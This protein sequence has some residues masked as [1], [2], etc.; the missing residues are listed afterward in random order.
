V[1]E[2]ELTIPRLSLWQLVWSD[3]EASRIEDPEPAWI[4]RLLYLPRLALNPSLQFA[5]LVRLAQ[6]GPHFLVYPLRMIQ[7]LLFSSE[8]W[9]FSGDDAIEIGPGI[10]FPHPVNVIIGAGTKIGA[11]VTGYNNTN[12]GAD[13]HRRRDDTVRNAARI[14]DRVV[15]YAYSAVQG[16][17]DVGQDAVVGIHVVLDDN[18]PAGA[19]RTM[20][21]LRS[22]GEWPGE[23]RSHYHWEKARTSPMLD[24]AQRWLA[25]RRNA[26]DPERKGR[27]HI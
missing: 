9:M 2:P 20:K 21:M 23:D 7:V 3:Y 19:L 10:A 1:A 27:R 4:S 22:A 14:G 11:G 17:Y 8:V 25:R 5:L 13:R 24:M 6:K 18:V 12:I 26:T 15:I 16:P